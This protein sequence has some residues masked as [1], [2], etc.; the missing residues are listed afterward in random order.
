VRAEP[1][2]EHCTGTLRW[3]TTRPLAASYESTMEFSFGMTL[4]DARLD[5][6]TLVIDPRGD[7]RSHQDESS[8]RHFRP[9]R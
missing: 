5:G 6:A 7:Y 9:A 8:W 3:Q 4:R 2:K 1:E